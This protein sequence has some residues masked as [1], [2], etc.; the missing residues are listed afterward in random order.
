[1]GKNFIVLDTETV[2]MFG[3]TLNVPDPKHALTYDVGYLLVNGDTLQPVESR[4]YVVQEAFSRPII[5]SAYYA[6]KLPAYQAAIDLGELLERKFLYVWREFNELADAY[7]V[8]DIWAYNCRFDCAALDNTI[9]TLS[10]GYIDS[11]LLSC[12]RWRDV[13]DYASN[14][15][16]SAG[17]LDYCATNNLYTQSGNPKTGAEQ[18]YGYITG[19]PTHVEQHT[20]LS[21]ATEE[22]QILIAARTRHK[23]TRPHSCGQGWRDAAKAQRK[24]NG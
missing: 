20:A 4:R 16:S 11:F 21:D 1:M 6:D 18:L 3:R 15:T 19:N 8:R 22:L 14:I 23:K 10:N 5:T 7:N 2:D 24:R 9:R 17:Y 13:W 12:H